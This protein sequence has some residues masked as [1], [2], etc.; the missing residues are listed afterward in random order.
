MAI[1]GLQ[2]RRG[3]VVCC[4]RAGTLAGGVDIFAGPF[5]QIV[6][7]HCGCDLRGEHRGMARG[8]ELIERAIACANGHYVR[9]YRRVYDRPPLRG[10]RNSGI[11][12][13][14]SQSCPADCLYTQGSSSERTAMY[15]LPRRR[16]PGA[17]RRDS[18]HHRM[19]D[20]PSCD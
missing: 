4:V 8:A 17:R 14:S 12:R 15:I 6:G 11:F 7:A 18:K 16:G 1:C 2:G 5:D 10:R 20:V 9:R 19:R 3:N 13:R